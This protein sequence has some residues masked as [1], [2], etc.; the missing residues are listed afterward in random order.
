[1]TKREVV[2]SPTMGEAVIHHLSALGPLSA[3]GYLAGQAVS[4]ALFELF[5]QDGD[6]LSVYND[7]DIFYPVT[8]D[9]ETIVRRGKR[10][11][12]TVQFH[13]LNVREE[14]GHLNLEV[15]LDQ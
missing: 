7:L 1:M 6:G 12:R 3:E 5:V 15:S 9:D 4:S 10:G 11:L 14:Y 2:F 13:D 8:E